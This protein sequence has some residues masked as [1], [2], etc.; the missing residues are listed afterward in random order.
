MNTSGNNHVILTADNH[1]GGKAS[2]LTCLPSYFRKPVAEN[3]SKS[4]I[5]EIVNQPIYQQAEI[6]FY[7][8]RSYKEKFYNNFIA[9]TE[10]VKL[11]LCNY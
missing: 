9:N 6:V 3:N 5:Y 2:L 11:L 8:N 1:L 4:S 10:N 7:A